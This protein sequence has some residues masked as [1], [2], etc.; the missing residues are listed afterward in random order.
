M[1]SRQDMRTQVGTPPNMLKSLCLMRTPMYPLGTT[2]SY[3][4]HL[5]YTTQEDTR[6]LWIHLPGSTIRQEPD[7]LHTLMDHRG[8][9]AQL[10]TAH[11]SH[12]VRTEDTATRVHSHTAR[13]NHCLHPQ[14]SQQ[15]TARLLLM[16]ILPD[17]T[18]REHRC[19][20]DK[21]LHPQHCTVQGHTEP[22]SR[23]S[24]QLDMH[25]QPSK[26]PS[27]QKWTAPVSR[28]TALLDTMHSCY[29]LQ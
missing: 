15:D 10:C 16:S 25:I 9:T 18:I 11:L 6:L 22:L 23:S 21:L 13:T 17:R 27:N 3:C 29:C 28:Q 14:T 5:R 26:H 24:I 4:C 7:I 12:S 20:T 2:C 8:C 1:Q 19:T